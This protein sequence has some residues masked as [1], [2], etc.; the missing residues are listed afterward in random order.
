MK[1]SRAGGSGVAVVMFAMSLSLVF[2]S[3]AQTNSWLSPAS[4]NW[5]DSS[6]SLGQLPGPGQTILLTNA[7]FKA[8]E[9]RQNTAANFPQT[10]TIDSLTISSPANSLNTLLLNF[11]GVASPLIVNSLTLNTNSIITM[12]SSA[13]LVQSNLSI[14]GTFNQNDFSGV[15]AN[16]MRIGD[17]GPATYTMSNGTLTVTNLE[18]LGGAGYP[19]VFDQEGGF[20]YATPLVITNAGGEY[21]LHAGQLGGDIQ[22]KHGILIQYGGDLAPSHF[23]DEGSYTLLGGTLEA[24]SLTLSNNGFASQSGGTNSA[25]SLIL[26]SP[27][28]A[29]Q[30]GGVYTMVGGLMN[31]TSATINYLGD[32][33]QQGGAINIAGSLNIPAFLFGP[34]PGHFV[35]GNFSLEGGNF[36]A[37]SINLSGHITQTGGTNTVA[38]D[39]SI[40]DDP[41]NYALSGGLLSTSNTVKNAGGFQQSGGVHSIQNL[42]LLKNSF[43]YQQSGGQLITPYIEIDNS[44]F[45]HSGGVINNSAVLIMDFGRW[46][47]SAPSVQLGRV[48]VVGSG[49]P[50]TLSLAANPCTV[51]FIGSIGQV[52]SNGVNLNIENWAGSLNGGGQSQ[53]FFGNNS[54]GL[55]VGQLAHI[56]FTFSQGSFPAKIL[57]SGEIVPVLSGPPFYPTSLTATSL[58]TN[59]IDLAWIDN[60]LNEYGYGIER[61]LDGTNFVQICT[62]EANVTNYSDLEV[63]AGTTYYYRARALNT[64]GNSAYGNIA[65]VTTKFHPPIAGMIS[66]WRADGTAEDSIGIHD[67]V[68]PFGT[69]YATGEV[70]QA[71]DFPGFGTRVRVPDSSDFI[72]TNAFTVEGWIY[73][74]QMTNGIIAMRGDFL[75]QHN[76]WTLHMTNNPGHLSFVIDSDTG[77]SAEIQAPVQTNQWQ[78]FAA[79]FNAASGMKLY[80]DGVL[81]AQT[82]TTILPVSFLNAGEEAFLSFGNASVISNYFPFDGLIDEVSL[83]SRAL[84]PNEIQSIYH[85]GSAGKLTLTPITAALVR[86]SNNAIQLN[87]AG[88]I[89][90]SFEFDISTDLTH[91]IPWKTQLNNSGSM[92][93]T[94]D[95][96]TNAPVRFYRTILLP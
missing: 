13:L 61:S 34:S 43:A 58:A 27:S 39:L 62:T 50:S 32:L 60:A 55:S 59:R 57:S 66:W 90:R 45:I 26:G 21:D 35:W 46:I 77:Q 20:H 24:P 70:G 40:Q 91:W 89:G 67:A 23:S 76:S 15:T 47:E 75:P 16:T 28:E 2:S 96:A 3:N 73:P 4:G 7:G 78:H 1:L 11:V 9:I 64:N 82:N 71:F 44:T 74:R 5:E 8:V 56:Q 14:G 37:G 36:S 6:W 29:T 48:R 17:I 83:Y 63:S 25:G 12:H 31:L 30:G 51:H 38:G 84:S 52:W 49:L 95:S 10:L 93:I 54:V 81:A 72:L 80:L 85:A 88:P 41:S 65:S 53:I 33:D 87:F 19:A 42:L 79:T 94:D 92:L 18:V 22:I 68:V 69:S 86:Q